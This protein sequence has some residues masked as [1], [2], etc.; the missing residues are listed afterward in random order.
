MKLI[1]PKTLDVQRIQKGKI[2]SETQNYKYKMK[3][4]H[5]ATNTS[6]PIDK[7]TILVLVKE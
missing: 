4:R 6:V 3:I 7:D 5:E 2:H 1:L